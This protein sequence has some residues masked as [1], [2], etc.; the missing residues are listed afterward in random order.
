MIFQ[1]TE[2]SLNL[3][4]KFTHLVIKSIYANIEFANLDI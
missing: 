1:S 4:K 3:H 2:Y